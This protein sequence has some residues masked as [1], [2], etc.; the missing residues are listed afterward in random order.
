MFEVPFSQKKIFGKLVVVRLGHSPV[1]FDSFSSGADPRLLGLTAATM[2]PAQGDPLALA[3]P[4][5]V[6][7]A[8]A[9]LLLP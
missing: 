1:S 2:P 3:A 4:L 7:H 9:A 6:H 8:A 5:G